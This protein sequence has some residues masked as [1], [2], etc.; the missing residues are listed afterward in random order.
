M[1]HTFWYLVRCVHVRIIIKYGLKDS[2]NGTSC[3]EDIRKRVY[4]LTCS[5]CTPW[6]PVFL[7]RLSFKKKQ[8]NGSFLAGENV[9]VLQRQHP[10]LICSLDFPGCWNAQS[11]TELSL[12]LLCCLILAFCFWQ[13]PFTPSS[14]A[15]TYSLLVLFR[16]NTHTH[17]HT[18]AHTLTLTRTCRHL[19]C[20]ASLSISL[21]SL[22]LLPFLCVLTSGSFQS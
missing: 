11:H 17:L 15:L 4:S 7:F 1:L 19:S 3:F 21:L 18:H 10:S 14:A 2:T 5:G 20:L 13:S 12:A 16:Q 6:K 8:V 9:S 22:W